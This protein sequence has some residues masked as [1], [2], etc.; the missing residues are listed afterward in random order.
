MEC[1][2]GV[3]M[4]S[5]PSTRHYSAVMSN[6]RGVIKSHPFIFEVQKFFENFQFFIRRGTEHVIARC[7][8]FKRRKVLG[9]QRA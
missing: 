9:Q 1:K 5:T 8:V 2:G 4:F 6:F 7:A 3:E